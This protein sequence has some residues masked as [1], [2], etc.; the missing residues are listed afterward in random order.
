MRDKLRAEELLNT[1]KVRVQIS[2]TA[3]QNHTHIDYMIGDKIGIRS[4]KEEERGNDSL[5]GL[6]VPGKLNPYAD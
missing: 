3:R 4:L 2:N 5:I 1:E 6:K